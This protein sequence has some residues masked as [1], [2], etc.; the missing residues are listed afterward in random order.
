[1]G[2]AISISVPRDNKTS[3]LQSSRKPLAVPFGELELLII[4]YSIYVAR[5]FTASDIVTYYYPRASGTERTR[6]LKRVH[7]AIQRLL[8]RGIVARVARG[9]Y[10]RVADIDPNVLGSTKPNARSIFSAAGGLKETKSDV[11]C[12][13]NV[14]RV[15]GVVRD[16][17]QL[18]RDLLV[19]RS[20][21][22]LAIKEVEARLLSMGYSRYWLRRVRREVRV[23]IERLFERLGDS[24]RVF[25]VHGFW[26]GR[27]FV[28]ARFS[29]LSLDV[30]Y[31]VNAREVGVDLLLP[32]P[33]LPKIHVKVYTTKVER[34]QYAV[35]PAAR[36][37]HTYAVVR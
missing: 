29:P 11:R 23:L 8:K 2:T 35:S 14:V 32:E 25:G 3:C 10:E 21:L 12:G 4:K 9:L 27:K 5:R 18:Y 22:D 24:K 36:T 20:L 13:C 28:K 31:W 15:H 26:L 7:D 19:A 37:L 34:Y 33:L 30:T 16:V 6:L 17:V 1:M